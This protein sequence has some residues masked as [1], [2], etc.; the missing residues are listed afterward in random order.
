MSFKI[1][2]MVYVLILYSSDLDISQGPCVEG[3]TQPLPLVVE[4][5]RWGLVEGGKVTVG[6]PL[7]GIL[8]PLSSLLLCVCFQAAE[9]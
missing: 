5:Q 4:P 1:F 8:S 2:L 9:R 3:F 7:E 6:V